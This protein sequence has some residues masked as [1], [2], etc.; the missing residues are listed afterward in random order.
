[1]RSCFRASNNTI[2]WSWQPSRDTDEE[3][4]PC[5]QQ[6][7]QKVL[8]VHSRLQSSWFLSCILGS[9][10]EQ[11]D[12]SQR[13]SSSREHHLADQSDHPREQQLDI[14]FQCWS[15]QSSHPWLG[16][17]RPELPGIFRRRYV[18]TCSDDSES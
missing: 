16:D 12:H 4:L 17:Q 11:V 1:M 18:C 6:Y 2:R 7:D 13:E 3:L 10:R 5:L 14:L 15:N 9:C 8:V